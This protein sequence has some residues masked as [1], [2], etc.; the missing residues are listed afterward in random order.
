MKTLTFLLLLLFSSMVFGQDTA[1]IT[2]SS[3]LQFK[4][5]FYKFGTELIYDREVVLPVSS[6]T[7][8]NE[9]LDIVVVSDMLHVVFNKVNKEEQ[10]NPFNWDR[11]YFFTHNGKLYMQQNDRY[12]A[13]TCE[14]VPSFNNR[15]FAAFHLISNFT[16]GKIV[17]TVEISRK[18]VTIAF[19]A[20]PGVT[21][22]QEYII[23][24]KWGKMLDHFSLP[25]SFNK[26]I[27]KG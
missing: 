15:E 12:M 27:F 7:N 3:K 4:N 5:S 14:V 25:S 10:D 22:M 8:G 17:G 1:Y 20:M 9:Q 2:S 16:P 6:K 11:I 19:D 21:T 24:G 13:N 26:K 23:K 18:S